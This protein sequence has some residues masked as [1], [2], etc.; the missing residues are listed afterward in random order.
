MKR[1]EPLRSFDKEVVDTAIRYFFAQLFHDSN[2][3]IHDISNLASILEDRLRTRGMSEERR[4][5]QQIKESI[6]DLREMFI[7]INRMEFLRSSGPCDYI[8]DV[9]QP[10]LTESTRRLK[11]RVLIDPSSR[12]VPQVAINPVLAYWA[13]LA[14][15]EEIGDFRAIRIKAKQIKEGVVSFEFLTS[16]AV[17]VDSTNVGNF[18]LRSELAGINVEWRAD[19]TVLTLSCPLPDGEIS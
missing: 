19:R 18:V 2:H 17:N 5:A 15:F 11:L 8:V 14:L 6:S 1:A 7:T 9:I 3:R 10:A 16:E 13:A 12:S 4:L